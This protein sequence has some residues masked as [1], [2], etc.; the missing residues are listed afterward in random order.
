MKLGAYLGVSRDIL[1]ELALPEL[2]VR[3]RSCRTRA[4][5]MAMP[6]AAVYEDCDLTAAKHYVRGAWQPFVM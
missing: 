5:G 6:K 4:T 2:S 1:I 3:P